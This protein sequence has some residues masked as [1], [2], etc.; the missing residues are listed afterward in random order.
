[1]REV[2]VYRVLAHFVLEAAK[3]DAKKVRQAGKPRRP[4]AG[5]FQPAAI[6][7]IVVEDLGSKIVVEQSFD[8]LWL[9]GF[10]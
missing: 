2:D 7:F 3:E 9:V 8:G 6:A 10:R 5:S 1:M 4:L